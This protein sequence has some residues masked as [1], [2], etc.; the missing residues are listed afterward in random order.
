MAAHVLVVDDDAAE[1]HHI[2]AILKSQ[3][4]F[5]ESMSGGE[6][7]LERLAKPN[8]APISAMILDLVMPDLDGMAVLERLKRQAVRFPVIV[9]T[10]AGRDA[11]ESALR[12][13]AFDFL[14]KP[15]SAERVKASLANALKI[16]ALE[17]EIQRIRVSRA[18]TLG[19][20]DIIASSP[21]MERVR[22]LCER[23]A[24]SAIPVLI[25]GD[26]GVGKEVLARAIHGSSQRRGRPFVTVHCG[27]NFEA[28]VEATLFGAPGAK[29]GGM[30]SEAAGGTLFLNDIGALPPSVQAKLAQMLAATAPGKSQAIAGDVRLIAATGRRLIDLLSEG[31]FDETLFNRLN[32]LPIWLPPL[33]ERRA[34]IPRLARS[35][36]A[37]LSAETG[38]RGIGGISPRAMDLLVGHEWP[39]NIHELEHTILRAVMLCQGRELVPQDFPSIPPSHDATD[40]IGVFAEKDAPAESTS[41]GV[42]V[43]RQNGGHRGTAPATVTDRISFARY[44]V[45]RL[46]DERGEMRPIGVLEEE[47]I[48]FA[49]SHYRGQ[50]SEVARRLGIGRSTL[51]RK[52]RD[53]GIAVGEPAVS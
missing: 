35:F 47:V 41:G 24:R 42:A 7:A 4:H 2:E 9:Q 19:L 53:Y 5:V 21:A 49:I 6:A 32:V 23:A 27:D 1:R 10:E 20:G 38:R 8:T 22:R 28:G 30:I 15:A 40:H 11:S 29:N 43:P 33:K 34:D 16:S 44:G 36:L 12:A 25:E 51:Y 50:M 45:T 46:L 37:R 52:I 18:D 26:K 31:R 13:G 3:G 14:V 48:R 39:Q 17:S